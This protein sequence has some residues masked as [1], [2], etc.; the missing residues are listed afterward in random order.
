MRIAGV[1]RWNLIHS[2]MY[3]RILYHSHTSVTQIPKWVG[4]VDHVLT[5]CVRIRDGAGSPWG[6]IHSRR[7][8]HHK[9]PGRPHSRPHLASPAHRPSSIVHRLLCDSVSSLAVNTLYPLVTSTSNTVITLVFRAP[10]CTFPIPFPRFTRSL[11]EPPITSILVPAQC[12]HQMQAVTRKV[13]PQ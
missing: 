1:G 12:R 6:P 3:I 7:D 4:L 9:H 10:T 13:Y 8:H 11:A 2:N 5:E